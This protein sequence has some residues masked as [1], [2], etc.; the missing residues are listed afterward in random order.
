MGIKGI[1]ALEEYLDTG[2]VNEYI[3]IDVDVVTINN[4]EEY[5]QN[6]EEAEE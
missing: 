1:E 5:I 2:H 3:T 4:I 6:G